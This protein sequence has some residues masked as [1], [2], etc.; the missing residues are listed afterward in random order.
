MAQDDYGYTYTYDDK[1][2]YWTRPKHFYGSHFTDSYVQANIVILG[3]C[4]LALMI[5]AIC[6]TKT[7][8]TTEV[9]RRVFTWYAY[10]L[11]IV[12]AFM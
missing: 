3:L 12:A 10:G 11:S 6:A 5:I 2:S 7:N 8:R 4:I 1:K 9:S